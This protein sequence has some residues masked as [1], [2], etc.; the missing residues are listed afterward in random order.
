MAL[1]SFAYQ[2]GCGAPHDRIEAWKWLLHAGEAGNTLATVGLGQAYYK[3]VPGPGR[4]PA[5]AARWL[6]KALTHAKQEAWVQP[7]ERGTYRAQQL[8]MA[9]YAIGMLLLNGD[10]TDKDQ[11]RAEALFEAAA[12]QD[13]GPA[14]ARLGRMYHFGIWVA[15]DD[16]KA[17]AL[18][19]QAVGQN[20]GMAAAMLGDAYL[21]GW[22]C[23][24]TK[25]RPFSWS[26]APP[27]TRNTASP[28]TMPRPSACTGWRQPRATPTPRSIWAP[29]CSPAWVPSRT[30][31]RPRHGIAARLS[32]EM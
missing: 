10:G 21:A 15:Q 7:E 11:T 28:T 29:C 6:E 22:A 25:P 20:N 4:D 26:N 3:G 16:G 19:R 24:R 31:P 32:M 5:E 27:T 17:V 23:P 12:A 14:I 8:A 18:F 9:R 2:Q 1:L 30:A 13:D